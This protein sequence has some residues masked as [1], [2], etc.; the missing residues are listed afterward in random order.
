MAREMKEETCL[1]IWLF[2]GRSNYLNLIF[3]LSSNTT[4][5][6]FWYIQMK[7]GMVVDM[8]NRILCGIW[9]PLRTEMKEMVVEFIA[10][11]TVLKE[12]GKEILIDSGNQFQCWHM[13]PELQHVYFLTFHPQKYIGKIL[14]MLDFIVIVF[15][16]D[17]P[18]E[19]M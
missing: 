9:G 11:Y 13:A 10:L 18:N 17:N 4:F 2:C 5:L 7:C 3:C 6:S 1:I 16:G 15:K 12:K 19:A 8:E 14:W